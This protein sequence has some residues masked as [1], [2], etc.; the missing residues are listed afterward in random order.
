MDLQFERVFRR[1]DADPQPVIV[2]HDS[3][4]AAVSWQESLDRIVDPVIGRALA[5]GDVSNHVVYQCL[6]LEFGVHVAGDSTRVI[7]QRPGRVAATDQLAACVLFMQ[8]PTEFGQQGHDLVAGKNPT[9][10]HND[11][12]EPSSAKTPCNR[13]R[14][15]TVG[16]TIG[17]QIRMARMPVQVGLGVEATGVGEPVGGKPGRTRVR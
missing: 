14:R 9:D 11:A 15:R 1:G 10:G 2:Q 8:A 4:I 13:E 12:S 5:A 6:P 3:H 7:R 17:E 16:Q